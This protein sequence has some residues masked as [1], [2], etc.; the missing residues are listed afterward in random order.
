[1][2]NDS[3]DVTS[4]GRSFHAFGPATSS[5]QSADRYYQAIGVDR[6]QRSSTHFVVKLGAAHA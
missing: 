3:A 4:S 5:R 6:T 1:V 2:A